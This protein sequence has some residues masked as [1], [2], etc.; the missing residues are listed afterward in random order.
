MMSTRETGW[1]V[2][3]NAVM[4]LAWFTKWRCA[5]RWTVT[6]HIACKEQ[7]MKCDVCTWLGVFQSL[8]QKIGETRRF[9]KQLNQ[10]D[11]QRA[12][13]YWIIFQGCPSAE[14]INYSRP[15]NTASPFTASPPPNT[16]AH[17]QVPNRFFLG[18]IWLVTSPVSEYCCF[19]VSPEIGGIGRDDC[20]LQSSIK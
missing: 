7:N 5:E 10:H 4:V 1:N 13:W 19:F 15:P 14:L 12:S 20:M 11:L 3:Y 17:F 2:F 6:L 8:V 18:Y 9:T 16:A